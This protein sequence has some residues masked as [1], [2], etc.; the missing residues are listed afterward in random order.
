MVSI[1]E[2]R[3]P[4]GREPYPAAQ[5]TCIVCQKLEGVVKQ[6]LPF[7]LGATGR[8]NGKKRRNQRLLRLETQPTKEKEDIGD[9]VIAEKIPYFH[10]KHG[11]ICGMLLTNSE[12]CFD[13]CVEADRGI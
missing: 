12:T 5:T 6:N 4:P 7:I 1:G 2:R 13:R 9:L 11:C 8:I 10:L 3:T